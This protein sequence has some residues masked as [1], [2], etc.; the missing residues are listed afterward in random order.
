[1]HCQFALLVFA[2]ILFDEVDASKTMEVNMLVSVHA[3]S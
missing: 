3:D 1:M 2:I